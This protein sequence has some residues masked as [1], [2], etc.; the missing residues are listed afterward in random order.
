[1]RRLAGLSAAF[2][3]AG[4]AAVPPTPPARLV[5]A[6]ENRARAAG[7]DGVLLMSKSDGSRR[8]V[9]VGSVPVAPDA[10]WRWACVTKQLAA[11][12]AMQEVERGRLDL[13][14]PVSR[15]WPEWSAPNAATIRIRAK[16][17]TG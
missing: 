14:A 5:S 15:Y 16:T 11:V 10:V 3:L 8:I 2:A 1:M 6:L 13:D 17:G 7:F 9:T 4:C 12:I